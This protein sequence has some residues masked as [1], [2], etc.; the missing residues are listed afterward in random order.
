MAVLY[1]VSKGTFYSIVYSYMLKSV[2]RAKISDFHLAL[3]VQYYS[4]HMMSPS[5]KSI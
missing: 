1:S 4:L 5:N 2:E 3:P